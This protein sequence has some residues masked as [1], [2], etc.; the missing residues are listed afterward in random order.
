MLVGEPAQAFV[1]VDDQVAGGGDLQCG[2]TD[3]L[4]QRRS[5]GID[6]NGFAAAGDEDDFTGLGKHAAR[7]VGGI[8]P[9]ASDRS[10]AN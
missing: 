8:T 1:I 3:Q 9:V 10:M 2:K 4:A 6:E 7:P 5:R